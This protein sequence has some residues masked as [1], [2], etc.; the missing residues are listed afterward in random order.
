MHH[1]DWF[2]Y[3]GLYREVSLLR[4]PPVFIRSASAALTASC[5]AIRFNIALSDPVCGSGEVEIPEIGLR[6]ALPFV[7]GRCAITVPA[8]P[9]MWSPEQPKLY[10]VRFRFA[11]DLVTERIG[12]RHI[13]TRGTEILLNGAPI[14]LKGVCVHEDDLVLGKV[15]NE[16]DIAAASGMRGSLA[17]ISCA[18]R[19]TRIT[20]PSR[21]SRM[22]KA[23]CSGRRCQ[24]T[25][26]S[27]SPI[28]QHSPMPA[29]S[30]P[31]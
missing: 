3:G 9:E 29:T 6:L 23:C 13:S 8:L 11:A 14:W 10:T 4:L 21:A 7:E 12:F 22:R 20:R 2:N 16:A 24:F 30:Y 1:I 5:G 19:I 18:S 27:I 28:P 26:Q 17:A 15:T 31:N 25:G